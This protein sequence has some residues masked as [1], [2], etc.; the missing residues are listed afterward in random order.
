M[1]GCM[2]VQSWAISGTNTSLPYNL[3][4]CVCVCVCVAM[5]QGVPDAKDGCEAV[6]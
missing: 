2:H 3:Y 1:C 6:C 4:E 5:L